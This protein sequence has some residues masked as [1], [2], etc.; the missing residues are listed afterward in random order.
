M[1]D[2]LFRETLSA[3][4]ENNKKVEDIVFI[5][6][7]DG[8]YEITFDDFLKQTSNLPPTPQFLPYDLVVVFSNNDRLIRVSHPDAPSFEWMLIRDFIKKEQT[9]PI[10]KLVWTHSSFRIN[11]INY[12]MK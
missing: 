11:T 4:Y 12:L 9:R 5:G 7:S 8:E 3:I 1:N 2:H 6:S 10:V